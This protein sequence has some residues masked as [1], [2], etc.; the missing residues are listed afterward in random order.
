MQ[1]LG[2]ALRNK[3]V[4]TP[5]HVALV[6]L[7]LGLAVGGAT[8][9]YAWLPGFAVGCY[10]GLYIDPTPL[11]AAD[12]NAASASSNCASSRATALPRARHRA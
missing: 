8:L 4:P 2:S 7:V 5:L 9:A 3:R 10:V 1:V 6:S 11:I 12:V